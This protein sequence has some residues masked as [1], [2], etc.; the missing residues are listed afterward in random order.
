MG[1]MEKS[2]HVLRQ[3]VIYVYCGSKWLKI[4]IPHEVLITCIPRFRGLHWLTDVQ[5]YKH[6]LQK[7][8]QLLL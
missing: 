3:N 2:I 8:C 6:D 5:L 7:W 1:Y 4:E